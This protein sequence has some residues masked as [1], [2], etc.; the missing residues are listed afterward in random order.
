MLRATAGAGVTLPLF[1]FARLIG[2][3]P[4]GAPKPTDAELADAGA[5][6]AN[7][8][9][10]F[11]YLVF[12]ADKKKFDPVW[13]PQY[14]VYTGGLR[15]PRVLA[16]VSALIAGGYRRIFFKKTWSRERPVRQVTDFGEPTS[17]SAV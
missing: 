14:L 2:Y 7:Q 5:I 17:S 13:Q 16:D 1:A 10:T 8:T 11:P 15:L 6:V 9:T 4:H 3:A 12:L